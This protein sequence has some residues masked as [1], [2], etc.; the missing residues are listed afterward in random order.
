MQA[1]VIEEL[2]QE[3]MES[4]TDALTE[5]VDRLIHA[6]YM[7]APTIRLAVGNVPVWSFPAIASLFELRP[8]QLAEVLVRNGAVHAP[9]DRG[10]PSSWEMF[11][12]MT[13]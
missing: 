9:D 12:A 5:S 2:D 10:I 11:K 7:P 1:Q 4:A 13:L 8:D 6:G 3:A